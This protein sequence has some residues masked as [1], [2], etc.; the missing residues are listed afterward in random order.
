[1]PTSAAPHP[2]SFRPS[3]WTAF[4]ASL[5]A[6]GAG[7]LLSGHLS[8]VAWI[9]GSVSVLAAVAWGLS[10]APPLAATIAMLLAGAAISLC[11]AEHAKRLVERRTFRRRNALPYTVK[12]L[13]RRRRNVRM[14]MK[15]QSDEDAATVWR[16]VSQ[17]EDFLTLDPFHY[18][19]VLT[20]R[21]PAAG[22]DVVLHHNAFGLRFMRFGKILYWRPWNGRQTANNANAAGF[23]MSDLSQRGSKTGFPHVFFVEVSSREGGGSTLTIR[24]RGRWT[25]WLIPPVLANIWMAYVGYDHARLLSKAL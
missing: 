12:I 21:Q 1:M 14:T 8:G 17:L 5:A 6:P 15:V 25:S 23:A 18:R 10:H 13:P 11:S 9:A 22:V 16:R 7:Q 3:K 24:V 20:R 2:R 4:L 19:I